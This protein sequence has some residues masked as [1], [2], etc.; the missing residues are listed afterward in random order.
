MHHAY[1]MQKK[2]YTVKILGTQP[3]NAKQTPSEHFSGSAFT[4]QREQFQSH[5]SISAN[6]TASET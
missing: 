1:V 4:K 3:D 2:R 6:T 5:A